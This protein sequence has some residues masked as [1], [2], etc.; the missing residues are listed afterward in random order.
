MSPDSKSIALSLQHNTTLVKQVG[1]EL[2][3]E[4]SFPGFSIL[5]LGFLSLYQ[6]SWQNLCLVSCLHLLLARNPSH[7][8]S[9]FPSERHS[10]CPRCLQVCPSGGPVPF[11]IL[12]NVQQAIDIPRELVSYTPSAVKSD[13]LVS[14]LT[15]ASNSSPL[16]P[17]LPCTDPHYLPTCGP[18][19]HLFSSRPSF[20]YPQSDLSKAHLQPCHI[21]AQK[22]FHGFLLPGLK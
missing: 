12:P 16:L 6:C 4:F 18:A 13:P 2:Q 9:S 15:P 1:S 7:P 20:T 22:T 5:P 14:L 21:P 11:F 8:S 3:T 19:S 17:P 10:K